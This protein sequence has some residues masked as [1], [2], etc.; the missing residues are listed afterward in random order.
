M[1][2]NVVSHI[3]SQPDIKVTKWDLGRLQHLL[4]FHAT[5]WSWR[6]VEFLVRE[7][8][9]AHVVD[10]MDIPGDIVTM[11]SRVMYRE[12]DS[13]IDQVVTLTY[14]SDRDF[15]HDALSVLTPVGAA[16]IGLS[17]GQAITY[18]GPDGRP[19]RVKVIRI[20]SQPEHT[21]RSRPT[22]LG[23]QENTN[24]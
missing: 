1:Q 19:K 3:D 15:Y 22:S 18:P 6:A 7:L 24:H 16:L 20:L 9:R 2:L 13:E 8:M 4:S 14:P 23:Q 12:D 10:E 5:T 17:E 11:R 21:K